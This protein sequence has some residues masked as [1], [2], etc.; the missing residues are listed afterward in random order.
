[1]RD[2]SYFIKPEIIKKDIER[3]SD[4]HKEKAN[5]GEGVMEW[6]PDWRLFPAELK[7]KVRKRGP[8][9]GRGPRLVERS[10]KKPKSETSGQADDV[11]KKLDS[12]FQ[13]V[14]E[15]EK[16]EEEKKEE[17]DDEDEFDDE[18]DYDEEEQEE[19]NDYLVSHFDDDEDYGFLDEDDMDEGPTY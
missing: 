18:D 5:S 12:L 1:M 10:A 4:R 3:F 7:I 8:S 11:A 15:K 16:V 13:E 14:V 2:S 17:A 6:Q 19:E 9:R